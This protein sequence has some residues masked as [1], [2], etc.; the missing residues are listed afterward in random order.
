[1]TAPAAYAPFVGGDAAESV[2]RNADILRLLF[3]HLDIQDLCRV[4]A[5]CK[6]WMAV[7]ES[8][9]FWS[10]LDFQ[11]RDVRYEQ[12]RVS[13]VLALAEALRL[14]SLPHKAKLYGTFS[15]C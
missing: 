14:Q 10:C 9:E 5:V 15:S 8:G 11:G 13:C 6:Q 2:L 3:A 1:M 4:G 7:S 12:V